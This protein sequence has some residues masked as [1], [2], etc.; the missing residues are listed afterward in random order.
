MGWRETIIPVD[1]TRV[2]ISG[3]SAGGNLAAALTLLV[4]FTEGP[5]SVFRRSLPPHFRQVAQLLLYPSLELNAAYGERLARTSSP[6]ARAKSL[7]AWMATMMESAYLPPAVDREAIFVAPTNLSL[8]LLAELR[9]KLASSSSSSSFPSSVVLTGGWDC[10]KEE[11]K[12]YADKLL[13]A[14]V[15]VIYK[16]FPRAVHGFSHSS[17]GRQASYETEIYERCWETVCQALEDAFLQS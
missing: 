15:A 6:E 17:T 8:E 16:E 2:A 7:P 3:N 9:L 14:G 5:C 10:L 12:A 4:S 13:Q 11:G 1:P